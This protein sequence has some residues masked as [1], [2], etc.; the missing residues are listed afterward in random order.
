MSKEESTQVEVRTAEADATTTSQESSQ[1]ATRSD[2]TSH[3]DADSSQG[4]DS[5]EGHSEKVQPEEARPEETDWQDKYLRLYAEFDNFRKRTMRERGDLIRN[6]S[7]DILEK[8]LPVLDDFDR[9]A[10]DPSEDVVAVREG[11]TLIHT[12]LRQL[13]EA[14]GLTKMEVGQGD[15]FD[16]DLHEAITNIPAP[17]PDLVNKVVDVVEPG[18]KLNDKIMRYAKVVVGQ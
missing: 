17:T 7:M 1:D 8:L 16:V 10:A 9:A 14:Q 4:C 3:G 12:K 11:R 15:V 2:A 18:Y 6:A 13:L 5:Q